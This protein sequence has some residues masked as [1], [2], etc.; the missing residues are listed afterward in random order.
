MG[1]MLASLAHDKEPPYEALQNLEQR[2]IA[3][4]EI[5]RDSQ[6]RYQKILQNLM[7][8]S[9]LFYLISCL[10]IYVYFSPKSWLEFSF[11][12]CP[13]MVACPMG[14]TIAKKVVTLY[15][16]IKWNSYSRVMDDL[17]QQ[18]KLI[19]E[20]VMEKENYRT[21]KDLLERFSSGPL[22]KSLAGQSVQS[23]RSMSSTCA[24]EVELS[25]V[26]AHSLGRRTSSK[27][28]NEKTPEIVPSRLL[29]RPI[30]SSHGT[31]LDR[32][33]DFIAKD[34]ASNRFAMICPL[35]HNHN[36]MALQEEFEYLSYRCAFCGAFN[37][38]K[39]TKPTA[40]G[41]GSSDLQNYYPVPESSKA[42]CGKM[43]TPTQL[44]PHQD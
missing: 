6:I 16:N 29:P 15:Y 38:A 5:M 10:A 17:L 27:P 21:A 7:I 13:L 9:F 41:L 39:K 12:V 11:Y 1:S 36:G 35:C 19:L 18:K 2:I 4:E 25:S 28:L 22:T 43:N 30:L 23:I 3:T 37:Q 34:G 44:T 20:E 42:I 40:P 32:L 26:S 33:V 14:M 8:M 24:K 31:F